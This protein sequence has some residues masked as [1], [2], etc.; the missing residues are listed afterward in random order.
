MQVATL[1]YKSTGFLVDLD[2]S[3]SATNYT[4]LSGTTYYIAQSFYIAGTSATTFQPGC[5]IKY[6]N[7]AWLLLHCP[8]SR[9]P[10]GQLMPVLTSK[11]DDLFGTM[12]TGSTHNPT[13]MAGQ[14]LW[15]Y[16]VVEYTTEIKNMRIRWA[17]KG[18]EYD[19]SAGGLDNLSDSLFQQCQT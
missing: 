8:F 1:P 6:G 3:G 14:A 15:V 2:L 11:D 9:P 5:V 17:K 12:V 10:S 4:F 19:A 7:D 16:Y 13:Y 18:I